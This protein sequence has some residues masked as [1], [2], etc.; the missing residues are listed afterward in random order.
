[1]SFEYNYLKIAS[2]SSNIVVSAV[3]ALALLVLIVISWLLID[4]IERK[5]AGGQ[6]EGT[7]ESGTGGKKLITVIYLIICIAAIIFVGLGERLL[8]A[9]EHIH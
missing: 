4:I 2:A 7:E 3:S 6:K 5:M 8:P 1:M 9:S